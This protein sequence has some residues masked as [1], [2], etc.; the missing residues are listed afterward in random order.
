[1]AAPLFLLWHELL[2]DLREKEALLLISSG[3]ASRR[4]T[5]IIHCPYRESG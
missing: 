5:S 4:K 3:K 1:M 2:D